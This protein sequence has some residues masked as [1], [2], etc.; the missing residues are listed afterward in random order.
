MGVLA[1]RRAR[2]QAGK[3]TKV[4]Y[5]P[6]TG[7]KASSTNPDTW[8]A[9]AEAV[10]VSK[11]QGYG[12][13]GFV[14]TPEDDLCGVDLDGCLNPE[15]GEIDG[16]AQEIIEELDSY[17][18][19]SPSGTG[20]HV[21][22][23]AELPEGR[24]R[25]GQFEAYDRGRC[26]T[27]TGRH[28]QGTPRSIEGR[29]EQLER[30]VQREFGEPGSTNGHKV[31]HPEFVSELSDQEIIE[32]ASAADNGE[33]FRR[34]WAGDTNGYASASEADQALCSSV[35]FWTGP[36][37][38]RIDTLFRK[39]GLCREKWIRRGDY[40]ERTIA[41]ALD[42]RSEFYWPGWTVKR[43]SGNGPENTNNTVFEKLPDAPPFPVDAL[44]APCRRF[45]LEAAEAIGCQPDLVALPVLSLLSVGVG[46]S[47][48]VEIKRGWRE[49]A[50][51]FT[52][53]VKGRTGP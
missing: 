43:K 48:R 20:V 52:A 7:E 33:K 13:I 14:F 19:I 41:R 18:E 44:P 28:L 39:S 29:Q 27:V 42:G 22:V 2:R 36:D 5:S 34:L 30:V 25:K 24:N 4:P 15:T 47:R 40:R 8:A 46:N 32:K 23:R 9:Y 51:L 1:L 31:P 12:G 26:F 35:A 37:P 49:S 11:E 45:V 10:K 38:D 17:T 50:K 21:L 3:P 53:V 16:W 6:L